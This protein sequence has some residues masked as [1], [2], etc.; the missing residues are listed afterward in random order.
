MRS[1]QNPAPVAWQCSVQATV[2]S[3][4]PVV[5][6]GGEEPLHACV[7]GLG[8]GNVGKG[9][10]VEFLRGGCAAEGEVDF[11][12]F[13]AIWDGAGAVTGG[14]ADDDVVE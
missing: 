3:S 4:L 12:G 1:R 5:G 2:F 8:A 6:R 9:A 11:G 13:G 10:H 14:E 7:R